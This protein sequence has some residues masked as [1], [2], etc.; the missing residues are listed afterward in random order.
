MRKWLDNNNILMNSTNNESK[1]VVPERFIRTL[2]GKI[3]K[4][5]AANDSKSYLNYMNRL[6]DQYNNTYHRSIGK[7]PIDADYYSLTESTESSHKALKFKFGDR[8]KINK[9]SN[10]FSEGYTKND[11]DK[12]LLLILCKK[13]IHEHIKSKI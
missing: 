8:V 1:S 4:T 3:Y 13:L 5:M 6:V 7:K 10:I 2:K 12:Y 9:Q 11:K